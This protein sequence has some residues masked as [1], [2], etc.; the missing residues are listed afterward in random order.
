MTRMPVCKF[1]KSRKVRE[2][3]RLYMITDKELPDLGSTPGASPLI[4]AGIRIPLLARL[5]MR[6]INFL[7]LS[8]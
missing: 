4:T 8:G 2:G 3:R 1:S 7:G 5:K 6:C